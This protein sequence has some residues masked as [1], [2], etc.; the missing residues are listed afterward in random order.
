MKREQD[1]EDLGW[2]PGSTALRTEQEEGESERGGGSWEEDQNGAQGSEHLENERPRKQHWPAAGLGGSWEH[3]QSLNSETHSTPLTKGA[4]G[5][6]GFIV[7]GPLWI[8]DYQTAKL[9]YFLI[10]KIYQE[11]FLYYLRINDL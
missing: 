3:E 11:Q 2:S 6:V 5:W 1:G 4:G 9:L 8:F 10:V 7:L